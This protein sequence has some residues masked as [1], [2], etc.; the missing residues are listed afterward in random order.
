MRVLDPVMGKKLWDAATQL[1]GVKWPEAE[2]KEVEAA[3][4]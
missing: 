4:G 1:T 2:A 3:S